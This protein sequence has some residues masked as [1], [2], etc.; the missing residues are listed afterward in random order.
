MPVEWYAYPP[1][2]EELHTWRITEQR[3]A[4]LPRLAK[5]ANRP[6]TLHALDSVGLVDHSGAYY[7]RLVLRL[8]SWS[9]DSN[10]LVILYQLLSRDLPSRL[11]SP[12]KSYDLA[13]LLAKLSLFETKERYNNECL[14]L[15]VLTHS[16][17]QPLRSPYISMR[18]CWR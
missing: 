2:K 14:D 6:K 12:E 3:I 15:L 11:L 10:P 16:A 13:A 4:G 17:K 9:S 7:F 1:S 5:E 18:I 8:S